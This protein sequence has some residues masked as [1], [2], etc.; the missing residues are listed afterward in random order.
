MDTLS[1][2]TAGGIEYDSQTLQPCVDCVDQ[3]VCV[4]EEI[5][6]ALVGLLEQHSKLVEGE[7]GRMCVA[8]CGAGMT[9]PGIVAM[10]IGPAN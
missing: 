3:W 4:G 6:E 10:R 2:S 7:E 8:R 9:R 1:D 5:A